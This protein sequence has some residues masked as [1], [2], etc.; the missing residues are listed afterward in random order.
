M[1]SDQYKA[2]VE[3]VLTIDIPFWQRGEG[4]WFTIGVLRLIAK[5]DMRNRERI[6]AGFPAEVEAFEKWHKGCVDDVSD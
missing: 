5:A 4:D 2:R 3:H 6:R 1:D